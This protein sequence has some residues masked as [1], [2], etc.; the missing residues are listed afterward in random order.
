MGIFISL[1]ILIIFSYGIW[2]YNYDSRYVNWDDDT[3]GWIINQEMVYT[4]HIYSK[5]RIDELPD[6]REL[7]LDAELISSIKVLRY[8]KNLERLVIN[9]KNI[10][11]LKTLQ[12]LEKLDELVIIYGDMNTLK[13]L[14]N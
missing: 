5:M 8:F 2:Y 3:V 1:G 9:A 4:Y 10:K 11:S 14:K 13:Y 6:I 12:S 7:N